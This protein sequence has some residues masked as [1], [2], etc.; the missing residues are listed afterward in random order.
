[1]SPAS[2]SL[3]F[4][5]GSVRKFPSGT[6][7]LQV[8]ESISPRLAREALSVTLSGTITDL[9]R[10]IT[11]NHGITINTWDS[12]DGQ[13]TFWH[14][15][16]HLLAEA[17]QELFEDVKFGIGPPISNGFYYDMDFGD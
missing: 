16:A 8:A 9:N 6:T 1:M 3:T 10:P 5:D 14:S 7:G 12:E 15:S 4:P 17:V 2:I 13:Q 11:E